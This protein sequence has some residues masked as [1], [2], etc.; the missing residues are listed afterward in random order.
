MKITYKNLEYKDIPILTPIMKAAFDADTRMH[1]DLS[2]DGPRGYDT[3]ELL[4]RLLKRE[5]ADSKVILR[6]G[7]MIG[8]YTI[9]KGRD[10][11]TLDMLFL[12]P[13]YESMGI[14]E[15]VWGDIERAYPEAAGWYVETPAYSTRNHHFYK[16]CGFKIMKENID[17][18]ST[19]LKIKGNGQFKRSAEE[20]E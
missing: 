7:Q 13:Q 19:F 9:I 5:N 6:D 4:E 10:Y 15:I 20:F 14:G 1:T 3:G 11:F 17:E 8:E 12:N 18:K 16:K 2:E